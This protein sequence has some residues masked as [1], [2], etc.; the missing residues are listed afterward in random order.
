MSSF[1]SPCTAWNI[2][3][4]LAWGEFIA[5]GYIERTWV[6][7]DAS[8]RVNS[9]GGRPESEG[10]ARLDETLNGGNVFAGGNRR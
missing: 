1:Q 7:V 2:G 5:K 4:E 3:A 10:F 6:E 8:L 9:N